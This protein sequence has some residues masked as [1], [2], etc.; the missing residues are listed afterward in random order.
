MIWIV[1][2]L[3]F[4]LIWYW[5]RSRSED[6][7]WGLY[8]GSPA[9]QLSEDGSS[10]I[11]LEDFWYEFGGRRWVA[12]AGSRIDGAS[13]PRAFWSLV[14]GPLNG[15]YRNA[16]ILHD[17]YCVNRL[18]DW[19]SV[20]RMFYNAMRCSGVDERLA[21]VMF[22]AVYLFGPRWGDGVYYMPHPTSVIAED[23][24]LKVMGENPTLETIEKYGY[25]WI[26]NIEGR[27]P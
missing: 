7:S 3:L 17:V 10:I 27:E 25:E 5:Y 23:L 8:S 13:I 22:A 18:V 15:L 11:L 24:T 9:V 2:T 1:L 21:K 6:R 4:V 26:L 20:H 19:K 14:G 12:T 16:S